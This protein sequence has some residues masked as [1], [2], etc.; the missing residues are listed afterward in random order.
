MAGGQFWLSNLAP[1]FGLIFLF[2]LNF[3]NRVLDNRSRYLFYCVLLAE[4][5]ELLFANAEI[6]LAM[7]PDYTWMR[8][9]CSAAGY[10]LRPVIVLL[11]ILMVAPARTRREN[12]ILLVPLVL[13][14]FAACSVFWTGV[15]YSYDAT[16]EFIRGPLGL[17]PLT[18][19]GFYFVA[20]VMSV[21]KNKPMG[22]YFDTGLLCLVAA[23]MGVSLALDSMLGIRNLGR[24]AMVYGTMFYFYLYQ[25]SILRRT[26]AAEQENVD[27]KRALEDVEHARRELAESKSV[28]QALGENYLSVLKADLT[29]NAISA[30]KLEDG[31]QS[32]GPALAVNKRMPYDVVTR[33]YADSYIV[34][35][36]KDE[37]LSEFSR[38]SLE[39]QLT[40]RKSLTKR[41]HCR[42]EDGGASSVEIELIKI[43]EGRP[44]GVI[45]G[46]RN[47]DELEAEERR[48]MEALLAAKREA[49][50]ANAAKSSF[51]SRMS[52]DIRTPL[53]GIIGLLEINRTHAEDIRLVREN[54]EKMRVAANHL[55]QLINEV[56]QMSK[57][58]DEHIELVNEPTDLMD[59]SDAI[60]TMLQ[61]RAE[62][63]GQKL[64]MERLDVPVRY[65][66]TSPL[67]LRQVFL[68]IYGNC[69]KYNKPGGTVTT[70]VE[71]LANGDDKVVYRWTI[72]D[73]GIGMSPEFVER[74]FE[75]FTQESETFGVRTG[76]QGT[77]LGMSIVKKIVDR[78]DG[79][80][81]VS[82]VK[83]EGSTFVVTIPFE[84]CGAPGEEEAEESDPSIEGLHLLLV[85]DNELNA[86]IAKTLLEDQ[87]AKVATA[88]DGAVGTRYFTECPAGTFDAVLMDVMMPV[89]G[90]FE[91]TA[92]IRSSEKPDAVDV[93]IIAMT[94]H[95]FAEDE[96]KCLEAGMNAHLAKP[97]DVA[98][99]VRV[100]A[101]CVEERDARGR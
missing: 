53:N 96:K 3:R 8:G 56:L 48:R 59:V 63:E 28:A 20:L 69:V 37:F 62:Q 100:V 7:G 35:D 58:E 95:A 89:M 10:T 14:V 64:V 21:V 82:S 32:S 87:G 68:N 51:L 50:R 34:E 70:S 66:L 44:G 4:L 30:V 65:V 94:A 40:G 11:L 57:L 27:L 84:K 74:I 101:R 1:I 31:Y 23:Y 90:G 77:G 9:L 33:M 18:V 26:L 45:V 16:N 76:R 47:V 52:H 15:V 42:N 24:T 80:I 2:L 99:V 46:M 98:E 54:Q 73:T 83:G 12:A 36:E 19:L 41:F 79:G 39:K 71:C 5:V 81:E 92:A 29:S 43:G 91:A 97:I 17:F 49:E 78:M 72:S 93:P 13:D 75:P 6:L 85:E 22:Q 61:S 86:E 60:S 25:A 88:C 38:Q 67:H 55:L